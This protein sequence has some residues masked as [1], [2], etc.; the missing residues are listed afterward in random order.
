[1]LIPASL[2]SEWIFHLLQR[3]L[4]I[5]V[6]F[7]SLWFWNLNSIYSESAWFICLRYYSTGGGGCFTFFISHKYEISD[8]INLF[9]FHK[10]ASLYKFW[11][12]KISKYFVV[13]SETTRRHIYFFC[14]PGAQYP[15]QV[16]ILYRSSSA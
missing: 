12:T 13:K 10:C 1:M 14:L 5:M 11:C 16:N 2:Y 7:S 15:V 6:I 3:I 4:S 9:L 8:R